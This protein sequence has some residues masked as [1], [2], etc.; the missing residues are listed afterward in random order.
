MCKIFRKN[1]SFPLICTRKCTYHWVQN[2]SFSENVAQVLNEWP[3]SLKYLWIHVYHPWKHQLQSK[4]IF[5]IL[6]PIFQTRELFFISRKTCLT[7]S[8]AKVLNNMFAILECYGLNCSSSKIWMIF[9]GFLK[10]TRPWRL[11]ISPTLPLPYWCSLR[12]LTRDLKRSWD[13]V[14]ISSLNTSFLY[15]DLTFPTLLSSCLK[16]RTKINRKSF[17]LVIKMTVA[18]KLNFCFGV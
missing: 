10:C 9:L 1:I 3:Q 18:E 15:N 2:I 13:L 8:T 4:I 11:P 12:F 14:C 16:L 7:Q 5:N 6:T 17:H